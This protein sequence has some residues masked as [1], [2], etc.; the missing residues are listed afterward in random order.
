MEQLLQDLRRQYPEAKEVEGAGAY[1]KWP[2]TPSEGGYI[3]NLV[4][5]LKYMYY[6]S[7]ILQ[8]ELGA[9]VLSDENGTEFY[10][11][12][13]WIYPDTND[14]NTSGTETNLYKVNYRTKTCYATINGVDY[15]I[16]AQIHT[17]N[18]SPN[19]LDPP[20]YED[21]LLYRK[22]RVPIIV[23]GHQ[24]VSL[25]NPEYE[26]LNETYFENINNK[27]NPFYKLSAQLYIKT[28]DLY[29]WW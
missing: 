10:Y 17:H 3:E 19:N 6:N 28:A 14:N 26:M 1:E 12:Q 8:V 29:K 21:F 20:S 4:T 25:L 23:I 5:M 9:Y 2:P 7:P 27:N 11:L 22:M 16:L 24:Q 18:S 15:R 13:P